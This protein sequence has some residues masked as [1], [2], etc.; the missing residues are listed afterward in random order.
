MN[1]L[2]PS[3]VF[4]SQSTPNMSIN[5]QTNYNKLNTTAQQNQNLNPTHTRL[6]LQPRTQPQSSV[7][8]QI[9]RFLDHLGSQQQLQVSLLDAI[10]EQQRQQRRQQEMLGQ[11]NLASQAHAQQQ[12]QQQQRA[13]A[14]AIITPGPFCNFN[15]NFNHNNSHN[16]NDNNNNNNYNNN[17]YNHN[18]NNNYTTYTNYGSYGNNN[19]SRYRARQRGWDNESP[20]DNARRISNR[21]QPWYAS[22]K[23]RV[24]HQLQDLR[25][26]FDN[27]SFN[28]AI[29]KHDVHDI[30]NR[31][32]VN[33]NVNN[34]VNNNVNHNVN[35][36]LNN[37][38]NRG[39]QNQYHG[40]RVDR[41]NGV[42]GS[43][44]NGRSH[45]N[46]ARVRQVFNFKTMPTEHKSNIDNN[47][48]NQNR[49][50]GRPQAASNG[51]RHFRINSGNNQ[52]NSE[53][54][55]Q[56][57]ANSNRAHTSPPQV[58]EKKQDYDDD[59]GIVGVSGV[60]RSKKN[61]SDRS[62]P[63]QSQQGIPKSVGGGQLSSNFKT[64]PNSNANSNSNSNANSNGLQAI[65]PHKHALRHL[66]RNYLKN[67][68]NTLIIGEID[69]SFALSLIERYVTTG[70]ASN[71][72]NVISTCSHR[73]DDNQLFTGEC[74]KKMLKNIKEI[75]TINGTVFGNVD[76]NDLKNSLLNSCRN[77]IATHAGI[78]DDSKTNSNKND[79]TLQNSLLKSK[80][81]KWGRNN[82]S[83]SQF[84]FNFDTFMYAV[85]VAVTRASKRDIGQSIGNI[86]HQLSYFF[87]LIL[88]FYCYI[89][90][91]C[92]IF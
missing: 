63:A 72:V 80:C 50:G 36:N 57:N 3:T 9:D 64:N 2:N 30:Q 19:S 22:E 67:L 54:V 1:G 88:F 53:R 81:V 78:N 27:L 40:N 20:R 69:F 44:V 71:I 13:P 15:N 77:Y 37:N 65:S 33:S 59:I 89:L 70:N 47:N 91:L 49:G 86:F 32:M 41:L 73:L 6:Q 7:S 51:S 14:S 29:I 60:A 48:S 90:Y 66:R 52:Q 85:P 62:G 34:N 25:D 87:F 38:V 26:D 4:L 35:H 5:R 23:S 84:A 68:K 61:D 74:T 43:R 11:Q 76:M 75:E 55:S 83:S 18:T 42:N 28:I 21:S 12:Q 31:T 58:E 82:N 24:K 17:N 8:N 92:S 79:T 16:H 46:G 39:R 56:S 45:V 10:V